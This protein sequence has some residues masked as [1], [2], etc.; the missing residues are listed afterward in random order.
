M[1]NMCSYK[2]IVQ[3]NKLLITEGYCKTMHPSNQST[4]A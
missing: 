2:T 4:C 3:I 1:S